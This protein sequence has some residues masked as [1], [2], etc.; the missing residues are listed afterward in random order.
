MRRFCALIWA[1]CKGFGLYVLLG[2][3]RLG[4][5]CAFIA[6]ALRPDRA[7]ITFATA[8]PNSREQALELKGLGLADARFAANESRAVPSF[9]GTPLRR[10]ICPWCMGYVAEDGGWYWVFRDEVPTSVYTAVRC[11]LLSGGPA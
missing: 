2:L 4:L 3:T 6:P 5:A 9:L 8:V 7:H 11:R 1:L 10:W